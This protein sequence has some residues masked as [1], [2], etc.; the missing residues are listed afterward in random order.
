MAN[1][2]PNIV[3]YLA[4]LES[5]ML[6]G[7]WQEGEDALRLEV[8]DEL[9]EKVIRIFRAT[10]GLP[11]A[12]IPEAPEDE[13]AWEIRDEADSPRWLF[14]RDHLGLPAA[15]VADVH[16]V[17]S[18]IL[19]LIGSPERGSITT[20]GLVLGHVQS[21]K[22]T[23][24]LSVAAK[25]ADNGYDLVIILA[26]MHNSLRRQ[27][28]NRAERALVHQ[29]KLW[30]SGTRVG[31]FIT[32]G[33]PPASHLAGNGK[34]GLL[35]VK[36]NSVILRR[37][38]DWLET[39]SSSDRS[40]LS[41]LVID[42]EADQAGLDVTAG[43]ERAGIHEQLYR[44]I[45]FKSR[46]NGMRV[47]YVGY[48]A[49]P[50]AN[51][52][53]TQE[54]TG[55][56]P[57]DFIYP[58]R[59]PD[60]YIGAEEL[61][62]EGQVGEPI[63]L[64]TDFSNEILTTGLKEAIRWF[65]L[66]TAARAALNGSVDSFHSSMLIH[67]TQLQEEQKRYRP[68]IEDFLRQIKKEFQVDESVFMHLYNSMLADVPARQGG[69]DGFVDEHSASWPEVR[70]FIATVLER[71]INR[72]PA[73][74]QFSEDGHVQQAHS[75]V[76]VDNS[77]VDWIDRLTYSDV[78]AGEPGVTIIAIGG[79]TLSRGLTLEGLVCSYFARNAKNYDTLMQMGRWFGYRPGYRH[80]VRIWTTPTL[81]AG[82][83]ELNKVEEE[84]REELTWMRESNIP[85]AKYG[86]RIRLSAT[87]NV[88]RAA[89]IKSARKEISYSD[90]RVDLGWLDLSSEALSANQAAVSR[91]VAGLSES[92]EDVSPSRLFRN[93]P[94]RFVADFL[95]EYQYHAQEKR[96]D[97]P[98]LRRYLQKEEM[99]LQHWNVLFKS[100]DGD[101]NSEFD[102]GGGVG[103]VETVVRSR[104]SVLEVAF[105]NSVVQPEDMRID[106]GGSPA[107][108]HARYRSINEPPLLVVY[109]IDPTS[110]PRANSARSALN[111]TTTPI[112]FA[113]DFPTSS[114]TVEYIVPIVVD[115]DESPDLGDFQHV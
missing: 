77:A 40:R 48:T 41:V 16:D 67:T 72:E 97:L 33:N 21:G 87:L 51:I 107:A 63:R 108:D 22:T 86:P 109:A 92:D 43:L 85:P 5:Y 47:A 1:E 2:Q 25:A 89:A 12:P 114:S 24:F 35:V 101:K 98:S 102:F 111:A 39:E 113:V 45:N 32:D 64:E 10:M 76:I 17:S 8:G 104:L 106:C 14:A 7:R 73:G 50:Y 27:T 110:E 38:A 94:L 91:L 11:D 20:R 30:W 93:V 4:I 23:N 56:Y 66:A 105:I 3:K 28:Q 26:G 37:L 71:L 115:T 9:A 34:R 82:F 52:L 31:D 99:R 19:K 55:L 62:G 70:I 42:D 79:N 81:L 57:K 68:V 65:V 15:A 96:V 6:D 46:E 60:G 100:L 74:A 84:L 90:T 18:E 75:G 88:T 112:S 36:K 54:D 59:K 49:T 103:S 69:G 83:L 44:I 53:T 29:Q 58:L 95:F 61:F 78:A 80:L 13:G